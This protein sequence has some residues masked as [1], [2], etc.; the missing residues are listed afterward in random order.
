VLRTATPTSSGT[1]STPQFVSTT[2]G[3]AEARVTAQGYIDQV[4]QSYVFLPT[5]SLSLGY[6][7]L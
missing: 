1:P 2:P 3:A 4:L 6:R 7:F 5:F